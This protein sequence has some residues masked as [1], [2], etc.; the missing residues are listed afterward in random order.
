MQWVN[1]FAYMAAERPA[2][3]GELHGSAD[4]PDIAGLI[5]A[6]W[7]NGAM[8]IQAEFS[9]LPPDRIF[10]LHVHEGII[11]GSGD[12]SKPFSEAGNHLSLC[13]EGTWCGRHPYHAGD[14]P[15]VFSD[16]SG[17]AAM[18]IYLNKAVTSDFS[19]KTVILHSMPD[20]FSSQPAGNS[21][22]RI[23]CGILAEIL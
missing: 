14:L 21:G 6:Y 9:G 8:Y 2:L 22:T 1:R 12:D 4:F 13:P 11:C 23:A 5:A 18:E 20:D 10:G 19:G 17:C 7:L 3:S 16:S 15:P